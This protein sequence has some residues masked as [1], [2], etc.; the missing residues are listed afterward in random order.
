MTDL[1]REP[2]SFRDPSGHIYLGD[3]RVIRTVMPSAAENFEFVRGTGL[4]ATLI[5]RSAL[6]RATEVD[7]AQFGPISEGATYVLEHPRLPFISYPYEWSFPL[8][9]RAALHH[10]DIQI[11]ALDKGVTLS[12]ASA[13]NIQ[14]EG[15]RPVFIDYL[16]FRRYRDG[17]LWSGHR[18]FC[19][20]FLAPLLLRAQLGVPHNAWYR[21]GQEG[22]SV[23]EL[24][25]LLPWRR[26]L[27]WNVFTHVVLQS[28]LKHGG[29]AAASA[30]QDSA[31]AAG[32]LPAAAYR[33]MLLRLRK[34]VS[35]LRQK[36]KGKTTWA[37]YAD[38]HSYA[39]DE[40]ETKRQFV[41]RFIESTGPR[42]VWDLGCNTGEFSE[43]SL[44]A[45][46]GA[47]IGFDFDQGALESAFERA[48]NRELRFLPLWLDAA[49]P[50][51]N[52]GWAQSERRGLSERANADAILAV[53]F[54]HHLAIT[55]NV[56]L[57]HLI[58][59]LVS[60]APAGVIEFVPKE[61]PM[62]QRLLAHRDDIFADYSEAAFA[63][64]LGAR[65]RIVETEQTTRTG[66][67][68]YW[69]D[70]RQESPARSPRNAG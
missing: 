2:G 44:K 56:P 34:W 55:R 23:E 28:A 3:T 9:G 59:W 69:Y 22:I 51:P 58:D 33:R 46:A 35:Q 26:K 27:S 45:G 14:F 62:V 7:A 65:A 43:V 17:E 20:Q 13:Y 68:M 48:D 16:S 39:A 64:S 18:Q 24:N 8:L 21:G 67:K 53:A 12:D 42:M 19:E 36:D 40:F 38:T 52:Q 60:L 54:I 15:V 25:R 57:D 6:I 32:S 1:Q 10:L 61:D 37:D 63:A 50:S 29:G 49:N 41:A 4:L 31:I 47:V 70:S 66:R 11:E 5:E 30:S